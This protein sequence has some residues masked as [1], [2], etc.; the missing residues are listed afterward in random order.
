VFEKGNDPTFAL[1]RRPW[2]TYFSRTFP[3]N[4]PA[5]RDNGHPARFVYKVL[6]EPETW[7][8]RDDASSGFDWTEEW[9][10]A[11]PA[12]RKQLKFQVVREAGAVRQIDVEQV[13]ET[14]DG[15]LHLDRILRLDRDGCRRFLELIEKVRTA[16]VEAGEPT[17]RI[18][19]E[20]FRDFT[21]DDEA[22]ARLYEADP[23]RFRTLIRSDASADDLEAV[24]HRRD[25]VRR[26]RRL[27][28]DPDYFAEVK[29][30]NGP[31]GV[32]QDFF[33]QNPWILGISLAGQ[34]LT[35]WDAQKLERVVAGWSVRG[36]GKRVDALLE[37]TGRIRALVFAEI[38]HHDTPLLD[39]EYYRSGCWAP[40]GEISGGVAQA[41]R[42][43]DIALEQIGDRLRKVDDAGNET[44]EASHFVRP[45]TFLI[46]G[47]LDQLRGEGGVHLAKYRSFELY[48]RNLHEPEIITYDELLAR[49][50]WH[51]A[52]TDQNV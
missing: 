31:E 8:E 36:P 17:T 23:E 28:A 7:V 3:L 12:V 14:V 5:S 32:W 18:D 44:G 13:V 35:S 39:P 51:V 21:L 42:T 34:L 29:G 46:A 20:T 33:E 11:T 25:V 9:M 38:K 41:Q 15:S 50:E 27:L 19:D 6:D 24:A 47:R 26:F 4:I 2:R 30:S 48:R 52:V 43:V 1:G 49:A 22:M 45:R 40:S 16:S 10:R 37:T